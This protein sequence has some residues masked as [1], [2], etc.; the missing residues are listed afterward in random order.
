M[1]D[2]INPMPAPIAINR[3][4]LNRLERRH[5]VNGN[6]LGS[7][8]KRTL[9]RKYQRDMKRIENPRLLCFRFLHHNL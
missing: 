9:E 2:R 6:G 5:G 4:P 1:D 7:L 8:R 3:E